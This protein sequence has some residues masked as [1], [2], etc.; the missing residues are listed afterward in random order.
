MKFSEKLQTLR[1]EN[2]LSQ[3]QLADMLDV[4]R[5]AV[6]KWE[7]GQT[8]P[9]MDKLLTMC[10]IFECSLD[11]LTN[12]DV[13][14]IHNNYK[15]KNITSNLVDELLDIIN[16]TCKIFKNLKIK[17]I[18]K[19]IFEMIIVIL[20]LSLFNFPVQYIYSLGVEVFMNFG[21]TIGGVLS[22]IFKFILSV[23][24]II[25]S[26]IIFIYVYKIRVLDV[27]ENVNYE[28]NNTSSKKE[29]KSQKIEQEDSAT[30]EKKDEIKPKIVIKERKEHNY[31][32]FKVLGSIVMGCIKIFIIFLSIPFIF[33]LLMLFASLIISL[34]VI[35]KGVFYF[36]IVLGILSC[37][38]LNIII[39]NI[40]FNFLFNKKSDVKKIFVV[41][42]TSF[43]SLGIAVGITA[44]DITNINYIKGVPDSF[45]KETYTKIYPMNNNLIIMDRYDDIQFKTDETLGNN[46]KIEIVYYDE[47][48]TY[49]TSYE[50]DKYIFVYQN[51]TITSLKPIIDSIINDLSKKQIHFFEEF[52]NGEVTV[53]ATSKNINILKQNINQYNK[54][55]EEYY[56]NSTIQYYQNIINNYEKQIFDLC[57]EYDEKIYLLENDK[58]NLEE[59]IDRLK[60]KIEE[61]KETIEEYR[62][63]I[64]G[65]LNN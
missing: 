23:A 11:D 25:L 29:K 42:L 36:G 43:A 65:L 58:G 64:S 62:N 40:I 4:S 48:G 28:D 1:K 59:E 31:I 56:E 13:K 7:S 24:Y 18:L 22:S 8:Y 27:Y 51:E 63:T 41:F 46:L 34:I 10:K 53:Y 15:N 61:Y 50:N 32:I 45:T 20:I 38:V 57:E 33:T 6:S 19:I 17:N 9:E 30:L 44:W 39:L 21:Q 16:R 2:K 12:D 35:C 5:Q 3:E 54:E 55:M 47:Y 52:G 49:E 26:I 37:I 60:E 14:E